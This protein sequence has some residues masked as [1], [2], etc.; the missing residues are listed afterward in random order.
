MP[1][2]LSVIKEEVDISE[3]PYLTEEEAKAIKNSIIK[4]DWRDGLILNLKEEIKGISFLEIA[5]DLG[6]ELK[7]NALIIKCLGREFIISHAGEITTHGHITP[8]IKILLLHYI[9]TSGQGELSSRWVSYSELKGGMVKASSFLRDCEDPL[10]E[11][12]ERDFDIIE[13]ILTRFG[14]ERRSEYSTKNAWRMHLLPKIP[15]LILYWQKEEEFESKVKILFD[16][17]ADRFLDAESIIFLVE[18]LVKN[19]EQLKNKFIS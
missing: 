2:A 8:W 18:G 16:S 10:K 4:S 14:A 15:V 3:C 17:T 19:L 9:R 6:A 12:F 5:K 13:N 11:L 7:D 1:F